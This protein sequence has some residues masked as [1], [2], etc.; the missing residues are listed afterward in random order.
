MTM[1]RTLKAFG[2]EVR[3][4]IN[5]PDVFE[6]L[7]DGDWGAGGCWIL[8]EALVRFLGPPARMLAVQYED[9]PVSHVV[10]EYDD[11]Y[12]DYLGAQT[13]RELYRN[14]AIDDASTGRFGGDPPKLV[15]F[16]I[17][18]Q[19]QARDLE[20]PCDPHD[21]KRLLSVLNIRFRQDE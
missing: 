17:S 6:I 7:S 4:L 1:P 5:S 16:T 14:I 21:V 2:R 18:L 3:K 20:I 13:E 8:A 19:A 11:V 10:V 12:I 9:M 15:P